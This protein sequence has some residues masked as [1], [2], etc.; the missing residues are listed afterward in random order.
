VPAP[1]PPIERGE[2]GRTGVRALAAPANR[3][4]CRT[5]SICEGAAMPLQRGWLAVL[6]RAGRGCEQ[7]KNDGEYCHLES[8]PLGKTA[9]SQFA[10]RHEPPPFG[11]ASIFVLSFCCLDIPAAGAWLTAIVS[12]SA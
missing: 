2:G 5:H 4:A 12:P 9:K 7:H 6:G 3:M 11:G 1:A 8:A 10:R